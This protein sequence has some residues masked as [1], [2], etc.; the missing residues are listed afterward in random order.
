MFY[1]DN[2]SAIVKIM[3][4]LE[5]ILRDIQTRLYTE[6]RAKFE[7]CAVG[8]HEEQGLVERR[9]QTVQNSIK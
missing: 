8:G 7:V 9:I 5:V 1:C 6:H 4:E 2:D 3:V